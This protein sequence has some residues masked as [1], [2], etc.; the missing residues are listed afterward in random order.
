MLQK[1]KR[2]PK[3][4]YVY[5]NTIVILS[6]KKKKFKFTNLLYNAYKT[7]KYQYITLSDHMSNVFKM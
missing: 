3:F 2:N 5:Q 4:W 7:I 1:K 6:K